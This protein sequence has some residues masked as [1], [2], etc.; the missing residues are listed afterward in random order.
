MS[1]EGS[2]SPLDLEKEAPSESWTLK[3][4]P[5]SKSA[6]SWSPG[7][8]QRLH[9]NVA[10]SRKWGPQTQCLSPPIFSLLL[11]LPIVRIQPEATGQEAQEMLS[12]GLSFPE[13]RAGHGVVGEEGNGRWNIISTALQEFSEVLPEFGRQC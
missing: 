7:G 3:E 9:G 2:P 10:L 11:L 12:E 8:T 6:L 5:V 4:G 13:H 1:T